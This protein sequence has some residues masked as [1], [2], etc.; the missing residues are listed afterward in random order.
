VEEM[1]G[2]LGSGSCMEEVQ[3]GG[4][5]DYNEAQPEP[6]PSFTEALRAFE[7]MRA[8]MYAHDTTKRDQANIVDIESLLFN[9]KRKGVTKQMKI[10]DFL[11]KEVMQ[12]GLDSGSNNIIC[13]CNILVKNVDGNRP[14]GRLRNKQA[15]NIKTTNANCEGVEQ[16][17]LAKKKDTFIMVRNFHAA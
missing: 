11:K 13:T 1:C 14:P 4:G 12:S 2:E 17:E 16:I 10:N 15:D 9:L 5:D 7:S 8:F 6:V 3:G